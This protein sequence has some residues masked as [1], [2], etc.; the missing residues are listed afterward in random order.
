[1]ELV[2]DTNIV[3]SAIVKNSLTRFL[4]CSPNLILYA[5]EVLV[6]ELEEHEEEVREKSGLSEKRWKELTGVLL[7]KIRLVSREEIAPF[8]KEALAF[9]PDKED[10]PFFALCLARGISLWS[11]D[12]AL[13]QQSVVR[14]FS[15]EKLTWL[16]SGMK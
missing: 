14:V 1:M 7:S 3:F 4:V 12:K 5:P 6:S 2:A 16:L 11:N 8:I 10:A 15:T 9:S 13:K